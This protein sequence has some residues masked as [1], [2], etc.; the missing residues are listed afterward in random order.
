MKKIVTILSILLC[1]SIG[2]NI[3]LGIK[4]STTKTNILKEL[5]M[6]TMDVRLDKNLTESQTIETIDRMRNLEYVSKVENKGAGIV[7]VNITDL[8]KYEEVK[9]SIYKIDGVNHI[10][11][12][13]E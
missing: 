6:Q 3:Y 7:Y 4:V 9:S 1:I 11:D 12:I 13:E 2:L 10:V 8:S 5:A